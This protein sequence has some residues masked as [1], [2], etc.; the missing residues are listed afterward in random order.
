MI[1]EQWD[2]VVVPF[3]F[4]EKPTT[5]RRPA[6]VASKRAFNENGHSILAMITTKAHHPWPGDVELKNYTTAGLDLACIVRL[7]LF[8]LD[9]RLIV[10]ALGHLSETDRRMTAESLRT[11]VV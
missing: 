2:V 3:P 7:K 6:L 4:T 10:K 5:K 8:T 11:Y 9:N 1:F